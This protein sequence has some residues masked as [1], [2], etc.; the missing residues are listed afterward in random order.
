LLA[1]DESW[2]LQLAAS[3]SGVAVGGPLPVACLSAF[4]PPR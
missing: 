2:T 1:D 3:F 4:R